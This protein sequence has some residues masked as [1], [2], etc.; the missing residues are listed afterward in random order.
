MSTIRATTLC[1]AAIA[2]GAIAAAAHA[3]LS[4]YGA[5]Y[6]EIALPPVGD[7]SFGVGGAAMSDGRLLTVTGDSLFIETAVG[8]GA[9]TLGATIDSS[10]IGGAVDPAFL[11]VSPNG[12][13]VA[14]GGGAG[15]PLLVFDASLAKGGGVIDATNSDAFNISHFGAAWRNDTE[16]AVT[17]GAFGSPGFVSLLDTTS[18]PAAPANPIIIEN[19]NGASGGVGFDQQGRLFTGNGFDLGAGGSQ[20]GWIKAFDPAEWS[21]GAADFEAGGVFIGDVLSAAALT[22]DS[23]GNLF[24]GGGD[25]DEGDT[26]YLG[27]IEAA[28]LDAVLAGFGPIDPSGVAQFDPRG[29]GLGFYGAAFNDVTGELY[30][31]DSGTWYATIPGAPSAATLIIGGMLAGRRRREV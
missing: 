12:S 26:G 18:D 21:G 3:G 22:F 7:G 19:I 9:F 24:V 17:A 31:A 25:F 10:L 30:V 11:E 20:T 27:G 29:D 23:A 6:R 2:S 14:L 4:N 1:C 15:K 13:R 28:A 16:L 5:S 8:S